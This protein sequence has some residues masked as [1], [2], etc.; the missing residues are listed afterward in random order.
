MKRSRIFAISLPRAR[1][2][3]LHLL[4]QLLPTGWDFEVVDAVD[5]L[6]TRPE[7]LVVPVDAWPLTVTQVAC[8]R[9]HLGVL[10][11][12]VDYQ[13]DHAIVL[14]DDGVLDPAGEMTLENLWDHL[15][16]DADHVQLHNLKF[17]FYDEY[18]CLEPGRRFNRV[19]PT[20][21]GSWG[22]LISRRLA[23]H[24]LIHHAEPRR[25]ID[26][27]YIQLSRELQDRFGF[28]DTVD[29]LVNIL[30]DEPSNINGAPRAKRDWWSGLRRLFKSSATS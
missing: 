6:A 30:P 10:Q 5:G 24:I 13:L 2:R 18:R 9:S 26:H 15:P 23:E 20:S 28:H 11:R 12:I 19:G 1:S 3:R 4:S 29:C 8:Y 22:Y 7:R 25:P 27:L 16:P 17:P 21:I 14:E